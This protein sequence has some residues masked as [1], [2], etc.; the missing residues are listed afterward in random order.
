L[1]TRFFFSRPANE[2]LDRLV[3]VGGAARVGAAPRGEKRRFV[4]EVRQ[5]RAGKTRR[6]RRDLLQV[7]V[8]AELHLLGMHLEDLQAPFLVRPVDQHLAVEAPRAQQGRIEDLGAVGGREQHESRARVEAVELDEQLVQRLLLLVVAAEAARAAHAPQ[9]VK[10][11]DEDD[12]WRLLARLLEQI[13]HARRADTDE[14]LHELRSRDR[15]ERHAGLACHGA[16]EQGLAGARRSDEQHAFRHARSEPAVL[17]RIL[18]ELDHFL[19]LG[20]GLVHAGDIGEGDAGLVLDIDLG[21][22][23][24]DA[25]EAAEPALLARHAPHQQI[26][27]AEKDERRHHPGQHVPQESAFVHARELDVVLR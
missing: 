16:R 27:D 18:E 25:H 10:L 14:H 15:E 12:R 24:A 21:A 8:G 13:A 22:A 6:H 23:L 20:L 7:D 3:E 9:R 2:A 5:I 26:P 4:H 19:Q 17:P 11:V 1:S